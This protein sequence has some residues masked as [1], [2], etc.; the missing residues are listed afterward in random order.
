MH[1][2]RR[3][4]KTIG[5]IGTASLVCLAFLAPG[6]TPLARGD[7]P[8]TATVAINATDAI[9][10]PK[11]VI[12]Y[13]D[14]FTDEAM[15]VD[16][17]HT[18]TATESVYSL[19][20]IVWEPLWP[21]T[22][23]HVLD[24]FNYGAYRYRVKDAA[25]SREI[26]RM[27]Y[28]SLF[29]EWVTTQEAMDQVRRS[30]SESVRFPWPKK[31]IVLAID[32]RQ[33]SGVFEEVYALA[34]DPNSHQINRVRKHQGFEVITLAE[35]LQPREPSR[36]LDVV[37][38][39]EGY[40]R[41]DEGKLRADF[42]RFVEAF[43]STPPW[44]SLRDRLTLRGILAYSQDSGVTEPRKGVFRDTLFGATFNT[45]DSPRYLTIMHTKTMREVASLVPYDAVFIM[46]NSARYGGGGVY[47][48]WAIF[49][50]DNEYDDYVMLHEFG[51]SMGGLGD[52]YYDSAVSTDEDAMYPPG[53]EPWEPNISAFLGNQRDGIKWHS[54]ISEGTPVPTPETESYASVVGLFEGAGYKAK[55][56]FRPQADCKM[57]HK[58]LVPFCSVCST[59]IQQMTFY[60]TDESRFR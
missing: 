27:G 8:T 47:N 48:Q 14:W 21:G 29:G 12:V 59:A 30:M 54:R 3:I 4:V 53:V 28:G 24:P 17:F 26:F 56:L 13:D 52:E 16:L 35:S 60:Y 15:R 19:D 25:S 37:I 42:A 44:T 31:P 45:F 36:S 39:P 7:E 46:V 23:E 11:K 2:P 40:A 43:L 49:T 58:G 41:E 57:F 22:R 20:E 38:L 51:H 34:I 55:G 5:L 32:R 33:P 10:A 18:G 50:S 9:D 6:L 1:R